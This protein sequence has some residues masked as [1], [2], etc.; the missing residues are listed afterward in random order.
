MSLLYLDLIGKLIFSLFKLFER[1]FYLLP[2]MVDSFHTCK[3]S[4][5]S[6]CACS[7][8]VLGLNKLTLCFEY[9]KLG[10]GTIFF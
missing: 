9:R 1:H 4:G 3:G 6:A 2:C 8:I 10:P 7:D 5:K